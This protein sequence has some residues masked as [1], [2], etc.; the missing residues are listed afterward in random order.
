MEGFDPARSF[1][2]QVASTYDADSVRGDEE[3]TVEFLHAR[4]GTGSALELAVGTGRIALPL[5][6]RGT[7]VDGIELSPAMVD[8]LRAKPGGQEVQVAVGDMS[9]LRLDRTYALVY[10]VFNTIGNLLSQDEQV[11]C[12]ENAA[13]HLAPNGVFVLE[14]RVP[15]ATSRASHQFVDVGHVG[16]DR[17]LLDACRYDPVSQIIDVQHVR[18]D[19]NGTALSPIRLRL[20]GPPEFDLMARVAGLRLIER[21]GGWKGEPFTADS[22]R[23]VSVYSR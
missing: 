19:A 3:D 21:F 22:W 2:P 6:R 14:C 11:R 7:P 16:I 8:Q 18:I 13:A 9:Q 4:A 23:H 17:V 5:I 10:L 20:A 1:G 12:F 15:T